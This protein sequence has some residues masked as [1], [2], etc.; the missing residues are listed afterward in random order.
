MAILDLYMYLL[1]VSKYDDEKHWF[2]NYFDFIEGFTKPWFL[3]CSTMGIFWWIADFGC[4]EKTSEKKSEFTEFSTR[5]WKISNW[6]ILSTFLCII[7][8]IIFLLLSKALFQTYWRTA[9]RW[10]WSENLLGQAVVWNTAGIGVQ[11]TFP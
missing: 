4:F 2:L 8:L 10:G 1:H 6:V 7:I 5:L 9:I 3:I 11:T